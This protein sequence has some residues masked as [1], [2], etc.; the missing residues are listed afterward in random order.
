MKI[1]LFEWASVTNEEI[2]SIFQ[3]LNYDIYELKIPFNSFDGDWQFFEKFEPY[4]TKE[5][6]DFCFSVNYFDMI[7]EACY[8]H[9]LKYIAWTY[10]SPCNMGNPKIL[11]YDT[12]YIFIF[13]KLE[14]RRYQKMGFNNVWHLPLAVNIDRFDN[15]KIENKKNLKYIQSEISFV[16]RLYEN[17]TAKITAHLTDYN[18]AFLNAIVD[19]QLQISGFNMIP[20]IVNQKMMEVIGTPEFNRMMNTPKE[21]PWAVKDEDNKKNKKEIST[22]TAG[23]GA[24]IMKL[25]ET[26]T[27]R[28]RLLVLGLLASHYP[29]KLFS[30]EN[31]DALKNVIL[32]GPV[33]YNSNMPKVFR[34]SKINM[35]I[36]L[37]SIE[38]AIPLRCLDIMGCGGLLMSNYQPELA[39]YF[40]EGKEM[41]IY[42]NPEDALEKA[43]Y[44][45][46]PK[47][48]TERKKIAENG[49]LKTKRDFNYKKQLSFIWEKA[50]LG[51]L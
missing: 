46:N 31:N 44:Y 37:R 14:A 45:L 2:K 29:L 9:R 27:N 5:K 48:E 33:D 3:K 13:D 51:E 21:L 32:C 47:H 6:F 42:R 16:G 4:V 15:T 18:K 19:A 30:T 25:C 1:L 11:G 38:S 10:D 24:L 39:E 34:Y 7:A 28:E 17:D 43:D 50:G 35:N 20:W 12:N 49:Y 36:S 22:D 40:D 26:V 23:A 41:L 8:R